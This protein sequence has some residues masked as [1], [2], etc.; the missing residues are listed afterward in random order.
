MFWGCTVCGNYYANAAGTMTMNTFILIVSISAG[1]FVL[2]A[3][4]GI[5]LLII[6]KK[7][8][9]AAKA[10]EEAPTEENT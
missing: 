6:M 2:L 1:A 7:R 5:T 9:R 4:G 8:K 10:N 3:G